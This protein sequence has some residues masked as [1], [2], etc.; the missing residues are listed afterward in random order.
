MSLFLCALLVVRLFM[1]DYVC[2]TKTPIGFLARKDGTIAVRNFP[3]FALAFELHP[4]A[5]HVGHT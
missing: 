1:A 3:E 4:D 2:S 5:T